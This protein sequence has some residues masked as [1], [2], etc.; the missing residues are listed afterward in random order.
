MLAL[1]AA[2]SSPT[3]P[4]NP[5][6]ADMAA[7]EQSDGSPMTV[8]YPSSTSQVWSYPKNGRD[9]INPGPFTVTFDWSSGR[10]VV[11]NGG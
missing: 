3:A 4:S 6:A 5:C 10:C 9:P 2:C 11:T 7:V 1:V 8:T